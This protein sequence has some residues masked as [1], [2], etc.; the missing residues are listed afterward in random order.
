MVERAT[1]LTIEDEAA[2]RG[3]L[4]TYLEDSGFR[5]LQAGDGASGLEVFRRE[6]PEVVLCDL[7]LP[8]LDGLDVLSVLNSESPETA[9]IIVSGVGQIAD[10][11]QALKRGAWDFVTKPI[12]DMSVVE[13]AVIRALER[14]ELRR[15]NERYREYLERV[16]QELM[17]NLEQL[18][19]D[20][21]AG[22]KLQSQ[23]LPEDQL[24][25]GNYVFSRRLFPS[26][27][28]SGDFVDYFPINDRHCAFY[29]ADVSG[30]GA[31]SAFVA[32]MLRTLVRQYRES[33]FQSGDLTIL[34]PEQTLGRLDQALRRQRIAKH[35]T[36]FFGV[37]DRSENCL[38]SSSAGQFPYP[39]LYDGEQLTILACRGR[40]VGLFPDAVFSRKQQQLPP[41]FTLLL[42][43]DGII[44]LA[45]A[46]ELEGKQ[47]TLHE[48]LC[49]ADS[50]LE[51][52][53]GSLGLG[54][55]ETLRDDITLLMIRGHCHD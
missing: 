35:V 48:A 5:V 29:V 10:A 11:V 17:L 19:A 22:R 43:S 40:P 12:Q 6:R 21:E 24:A 31:A 3:A 1:V 4:V 14:A 55:I 52:L 42:M 7:R 18:Q 50:S 27:Y 49:L 28:L 54:Q 53:S 20:A 47:K 2:V 46:G 25:I 23:L 39:M 15:Q 37:I 41:S 33:F 26:T 38:L 30:H 34:N 16:N 9:V 44:E 32:V 8:C 51:S 45:P 36:M 13:N